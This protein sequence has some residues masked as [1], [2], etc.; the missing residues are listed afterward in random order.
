MD[1]Y[2]IMIGNDNSNLFNNENDDDDDDD[3]YYYYI[4]IMILVLLSFGDPFLVNTFR[5]RR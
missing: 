3:Y 5:K 1:N 4:T 2:M